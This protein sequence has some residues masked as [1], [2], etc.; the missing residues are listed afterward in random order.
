LS[1]QKTIAIVA[2][3]TW[4]I[5]NFRLNIIEKLLNK[6]HRVIVFAPIDEYLIYKELF[7]T[8]KHVD[9]RTLSRY[10]INPIRDLILIIE[11]IRKYRKFR[12]DLILHYTNKPN[13]YGA[14]ASKFSGI[15]S[16]AT[17][18][19][20][21]YAFI[22]KGA[23]SRITK[24]LYKLSSRYH[25]LLIFQNSADKELFLNNKMISAS[26]TRLIKGSGVDTAYY[27]P[28]ENGIDLSRITFT[29]IGRLLY[30]KGIVE[31]VNAAKEIVKNYPQARFWVIGELDEDNPSSVE[32]DS[33]NQWMDEK[34]I[35]YRGFEKDIRASLHKTD[36]VILPSYREGLP[37]IILEALA[38]GKPVITTQTAGCEETVTHGQNGYLVP[39]RSAQ[40]LA[41]AIKKFIALSFD[42]RKRMGSLGRYKAINE[43]DSKIIATQVYTLIEETLDL[44]D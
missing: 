31:F 22:H 20:L 40:K 33:L 1:S 5:Y 4:N 32:R 10:G 6:G 41:E 34:I 11:L 9:L 15:P 44:S 30:D 35:E 8:V 29:F 25:K 21:G 37:R 36:C 38:M 14:I 16:I 17:I 26:K 42:E 39:V 43:F 2:N 13:I 12:P 28:S 19:G 18:T 3:T 27:V 24:F 23:V 7:P